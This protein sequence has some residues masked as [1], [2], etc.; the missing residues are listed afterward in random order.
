LPLP[1][2]YDDMAELV[3]SVMRAVERERYSVSKTETDR[4]T[5]TASGLGISSAA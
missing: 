2:R 5:R 1:E 4:K 3:M